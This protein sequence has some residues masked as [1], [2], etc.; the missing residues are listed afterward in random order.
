MQEQQQDEQK[1]FVVIT[2][3]RQ[4]VR[5]VCGDQVADRLTD[6]DMARLA[7]EM[8]EAYVAASFVDDMQETIEDKFS[9]SSQVAEG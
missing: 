3:S 2:I 7:E 4:E 8:A 5:A 1:V 9:D 6:A